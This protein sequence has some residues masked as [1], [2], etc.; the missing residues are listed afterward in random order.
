MNRLKKTPTLT[1]RSSRGQHLVELMAGLIV[2]IPVFMML[3]DLVFV[4]M[5][6]QVNDSA[7]RD[8]ARAASQVPPELGAPAGDSEVPPTA[9]MYLRANAVLKQMYGNSVCK[10]EIKAMT[11]D[12]MTRPDGQLG[13]LFGGQVSVRTEA[14]VVPPVAIPLVTDSLTFTHKS[15]STFP[16]TANQAATVIPP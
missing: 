4:F 15:F 3:I 16:L 11:L 9:A 7:S 1:L 8:A 13:G 2:V 10:P 14:K 12:N 5:A 6:V